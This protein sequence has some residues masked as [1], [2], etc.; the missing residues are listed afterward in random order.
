V[1]IVSGVIAANESA[2]HSD[3]RRFL[4]LDATRDRLPEADAVLCREVLFHLSFSDIWRVIGNLHNSGAKYLIATNDSG[5]TFNADILSGDYRMLNLH[6]SPFFFP[7]PL[8][9]IPD[10]ALASSR[11]LAVWNVTDLPG[12]GHE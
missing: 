11:V 2:Y 6:K 3:R 8:L 12:V 9:S 10:D 1:D 4:V 5:R 7:P